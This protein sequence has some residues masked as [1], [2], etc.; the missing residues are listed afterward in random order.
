M[1]FLATGDV[2][3]IVNDFLR[4]LMASLC[5]IIYTMIASAYQ[6]FIDLG[7][8]TYSDK[9]TKIYDKISLL[10]GIFMVFRVIFWLIELLVSPD[11]LTDKEKNPGK[12]ITKVLITVLLLALTPRI[13]KIAFNIQYS[14]ISNGIIEKVIA[15]EGYDTDAS[16]TGREIAADLFINFYTANTL[17]GGKIDEVCSLY[18]GEGG[19][20]HNL[21]INE[22][23]LQNLSIDCLTK[24]G[25]L[26]PDPVLGSTPEGY[27]IDF[28]GI[29]AVGVGAVVLWMII[30]YCISLGARY[31]QL[32]FLQIIAPI[33]IMCYLTPNKD[34]MFSKWLKQCTT[35]YLDL[36]IRVAIISFVLLLS[37]LI[38][39]NENN[40]ILD[41]ANNTQGGWLKIFLVLGLL[42]FAKKAPELIQELLPKGLTKASG[43]FGLSLKKRTDSMIGGK[44]LYGAASTAGRIIGK[45]ATVGV[46]GAAITGAVG[47]LGG[48]GTGRLTGAL[49]GMWRG[50]A[51]GTQKG[52]VFKNLQGGIKRQQEVNKRK[53][54][55]E[56]NGSTLGGRIQQRL[57]NTFGYEGKAESFENQIADHDKT[58]TKLNAQSSALSEVSSSVGKME[59]RA[60]S[61]LD[62][63][64]FKPTQ[65]Y[66]RDL[67]ERRRNYRALNKYMESGNEA[68]ALSIANSEW[69]R[70]QAKLTALVAAGKAPGDEEYD[71]VNK[72]WH[73]IDDIRAAIEGKTYNA[74]K[75]EGDL[76][77]VLTETRNEYI[78]RSLQDEEGDQAIKNEAEHIQEVAKHADNTEIFKGFKASANGDTYEAFDAFSS[79]AKKANTGLVAE[80][81][82]TKTAKEALVNSEEK[83][84]ADADRNAVG[85]H[86]GGKK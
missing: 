29:F 18:V 37:K 76:T 41:V 26:P 73:R 56:H 15:I 16:N 75:A 34:S 5:E 20:Y 47:F 77:D 23:K 60:T 46:A 64:T 52:S 57:A 58:L 27:V 68:A 10:I 7:L 71:A 1:N 82:K 66:Q 69:N 51:S 9:L 31:A 14:I 50:L 45:G 13:F 22:G 84:A 63:K 32:V 35:T 48:R 6:L 53:I 40:V 67:Q 74:A 4:G 43:D 59:D 72:E 25:T 85:G 17:A 86:H 8:L 42:I 83:H 62:N 61:Q 28:N 80:I 81:Y 70:V 11:K 54:D 36:F 24:K 39:A 30:M 3:G 33:P 49:G 21:L 78:S 2:P 65:T 79:E 55:W 38:L 19:Y 44:Y 12:I